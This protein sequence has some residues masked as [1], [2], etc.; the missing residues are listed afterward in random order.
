MKAVDTNI[1][2]RF[3]LND[4]AQQ[5]PIARETLKGGVFISNSV[6][7]E[8]VWLL[9]SRYNQQPAN[10]AAALKAVIEIPGVQV[11]KAEAAI[12]A[13][14]RYSAGADFADM[15]HLV[16]GT[17]SDVFLTFDRK[18]AKQA[19]DAAPLSIELLRV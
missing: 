14:S 18:L 9:Q 13:L 7:L 2:A 19:G 12:W 15:L 16:E 17:G 8:T 5:S 10:I 3:V 11:S 6:L 4:D 1:L